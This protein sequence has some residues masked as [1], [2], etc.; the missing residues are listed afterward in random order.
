HA[1]HAL[2]RIWSVACLLLPTGRRAY[3]CDAEDCPPQ[4]LSPERRGVVL[5]GAGWR[6]RGRTRRLELCESH[7]R[8]ATDQG[9]PG[10]LLAPD[11]RWV[12]GGGGGFGACAQ[13]L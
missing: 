3:G 9:L 8:R 7:P 2:A 11:G 10:L 4:F 1:R 6:P 13:P 12:G 5:D